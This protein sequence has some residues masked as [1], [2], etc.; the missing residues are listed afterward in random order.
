MTKADGSGLRRATP[1]ERWPAVDQRAWLAATRGGDP[2]GDTGPAAHWRPVTK[3]NVAKLYGYWLRFLAD[4]GLLDESVAPDDRVCPERMAA[5]VEALRGSCADSSMASYLDAL[6][7]ALRIMVPDSDWSWLSRAARRLRKSGPAR[8]DKQARIRP[9]RILLRLGQ[10]L[11]REAE[12]GDVVGT[13]VRAIRYRDGLMI[14]MLVAAPIRLKN[15]SSVVIGRNLIRTGECFRLHFPPEETKTHRLLEEPLP[16]AFTPSIERY[17]TAYRPVLLRGRRSE[18]LWV[19]SRSTALRPDSIYA[20]I[21]SRTERAFGVPINPHLFRDCSV[22]T[23]AIEDPEHVGIAS[24]IL[25]HADPRTTVKYYNQ[26]RM[27][28]ASRAYNSVMR[29]LRR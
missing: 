18:H 12:E 16:P 4:R 21:T 19:S 14:A 10:K 3:A 9:A 24:T 1:F 17:L 7:M 6:R 22:T 25:G 26:A 28:S 20:Q 27:L 23:I 5:Y 15:F 13:T 29:D 2:F 11:M 8:R